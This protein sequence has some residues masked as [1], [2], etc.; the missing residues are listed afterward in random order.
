MPG[1]H[2]SLHNDPEVL[3]PDTFQSTCEDIF[4]EIY[5]RTPVDTGYCQ[6]QWEI[7]FVGSNDCEIWND[8]SY[9][10]Y[11]EDGHSKQAPH[12]MVQIVLDKFSEISSDMQ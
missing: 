9:A 3:D 6:S 1:I 4:N 8:C 5:G 10:S 11:L 12:G 7:Q 2:I